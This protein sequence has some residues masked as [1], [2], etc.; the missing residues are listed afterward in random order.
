MNWTEE[1]DI[2]IEKKENTLNVT[3]S[4]NHIYGKSNF[5]EKTYTTDFIISYLKEKNIKFN[6][7]IQETVVFNYQSQDRCSGTWIFSLPKQTKTK[8]TIQ[9][10]EN[11]ENVLKVSNKKTTKK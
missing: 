5:Q 10:L 1:I 2:N 6:N 8:K 3:L 11:K 4:V 7:P 9:T